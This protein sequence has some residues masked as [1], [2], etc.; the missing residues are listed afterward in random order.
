[1]HSTY[2][3]SEQNYS[4]PKPT[5]L[6]ALVGGSFAT[7]VLSKPSGVTKVFASNYRT[8]MDS[9]QRSVDEVESGL[10]ALNVHG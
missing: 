10:C 4:T 3:D 5:G 9:E 8:Y 7:S 1:M 2:T 6:Y